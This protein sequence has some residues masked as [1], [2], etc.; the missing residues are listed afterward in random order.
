[1]LELLLFLPVC[2]YVL[3]MHPVISRTTAISLHPYKSEPAIDCNDA[4]PP[5]PPKNRNQNVSPSPEV[6]RKKKHKRNYVVM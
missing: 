3:E 2:D 1:M 5:L 4:P 6:Y